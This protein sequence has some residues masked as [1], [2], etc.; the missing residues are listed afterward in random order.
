PFPGPAD[1]RVV[2]AAEDHGHAADQVVLD[3][4]GTARAGRLHRRALDP[5]RLRSQLTEQAGQDT[6]EGKSGVR[7]LHGCRGWCSRTRGRVDVVNVRARR[8]QCDGKS[9]SMNAELDRLRT[10]ASEAWPRGHLD[11]L[12][13]PDG[14][15]DPVPAGRLPLAPWFTIRGSASAAVSPARS[16]IADPLQEICRRIAMRTRWLAVACV[17]SALARRAPAHRFGFTHPMLPVA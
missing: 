4:V 12:D 1:D 8:S 10:G 16:D 9:V 17:S 15:A 14:Y 6:D 11:T 7:E 2:V 13:T 5:T 3:Q